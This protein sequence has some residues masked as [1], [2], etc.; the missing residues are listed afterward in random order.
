MRDNKSSML[1]AEVDPGPESTAPEPE[2]PEEGQGSGVV[3]D[4]NCDNV[5]AD[6]VSQVM[7]TMYG[8]EA[9]NDTA[10]LGPTPTTEV[11]IDGT[12]VRVLLD[13]GSLTSIISR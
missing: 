9:G 12:P 1:Q 4:N 6:A 8:V 10:T 13:T 2:A 5:V 3:P 7:A 11:L